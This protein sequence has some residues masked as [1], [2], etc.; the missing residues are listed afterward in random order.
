MSDYIIS[1]QST[2]STI[3]VGFF[4]DP[5]SIWFIL[6][7]YRIICLGEFRQN[8]FSSPPGQSVRIAKT[9]IMLNRINAL[10]RL[11]ET[12]FCRVLQVTFEWKTLEKPVYF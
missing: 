4:F 12:T 7:D 10:I 11:M 1:F 3:F 6:C 2:V 8:F 9:L 5:A